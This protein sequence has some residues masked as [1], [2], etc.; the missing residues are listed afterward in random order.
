MNNLTDYQKKVII[1][2]NS[3]FTVLCIGFGAIVFLM[4]LGRY[5]ILNM[6]LWIVYLMYLI[7]IVTRFKKTKRALMKR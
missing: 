1:L 7:F 4:A 6:I 2:L 5:L 3:I